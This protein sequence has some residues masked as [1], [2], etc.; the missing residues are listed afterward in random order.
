MPELRRLELTRRPV[1]ARAARVLKHDKFRSLTRLGLDQCRLTDTAMDELVN[2][3]ALQNLIE[4]D[5][6]RTD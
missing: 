4:F 3:P 2:A 5:A 6:R 1:G